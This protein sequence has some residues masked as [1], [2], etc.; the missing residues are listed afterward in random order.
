[1]THGALVGVV[2]CTLTLLVPGSA[3]FALQFM[4]LAVVG[5]G[6]GFL[7]GRQWRRTRALDEAYDLLVANVEREMQVND[8]R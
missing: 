2:I 1:M 7:F 5:F 6:I 3:Y 4:F 8:P